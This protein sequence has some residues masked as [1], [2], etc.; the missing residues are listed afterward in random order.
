[1]QRQLPAFSWV[2]SLWLRVC[3]VSV[4]PR[5]KYRKQQQKTSALGKQDVIAFTSVIQSR[6]A[7]RVDSV[8]SRKLGSARTRPRVPSVRL[9]VTRVICI[10]T[11]DERI[12]EI[13]S[14]PDRPIIL[15]FVTKGRC[16][17]LTASLPTGVPNTRG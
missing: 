5:Y 10:K 4:R 7:I 17:N 13:L 2:L 15:V 9:S 14:R 16:V 8:P 11:A 6:F 1:M 3:R 12:I